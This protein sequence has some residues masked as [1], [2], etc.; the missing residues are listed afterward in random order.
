VREI[1]SLQSSPVL[2][3]R[4]VIKQA[5]LVL[6]EIDARI[7]TLNAM[8]HAVSVIREGGGK[9]EESVAVVR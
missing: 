8:R 2:P 1:L 3:R 4:I 5:D 7:T 6:E 9:Q